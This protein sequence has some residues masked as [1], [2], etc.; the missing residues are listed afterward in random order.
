LGGYFELLALRFALNVELCLHLLNKPPILIRFEEMA[1][2][3][4]PTLRL[5]FREEGHYA[6]VR[7]KGDNQ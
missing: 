6:S 2:E 7:K 1:H 3:E 5:A 4:L